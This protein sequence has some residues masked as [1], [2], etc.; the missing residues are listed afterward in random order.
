LFKFGTYEKLSLSVIIE[1]L[2]DFILVLIEIFSLGVKAEAPRAKI[3][4]KAAFSKSV[5]FIDDITRDAYP[6][7]AIT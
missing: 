1:L 7:A 3:D 4:Q 2:S 6:K 5:T